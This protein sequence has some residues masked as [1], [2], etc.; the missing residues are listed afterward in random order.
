MQFH[1][2]TL[3]NRPK[4]LH[5]YHSLREAGVAPS[6]HTY[7]LLLDSYSL[8][9]PLDLESLQAVFNE[10]CQDPQVPVQGVHWASLITAYGDIARDVEKALAIFE[11]IPTHPASRGTVNI[12]NEAVVW[13][14]LLGVL[15]TRGT[16][17]QMETYSQ[18]LRES[19][20]KITAY[21]CN[22]LIGGYARC[23]AMDKAREVFESMGDG[24]MGVAAPNNH[25]VLLTSSG[26]VKPSTM[27]TEPTRVVFREPSTYETMIRVEVQ[28]GQTLGGDTED[29]INRAKVILSKM[30]DRG[31]PIAVFMRAKSFLDNALAERTAEQG[32]GTGIGAGAEDFDK[33][34]NRIVSGGYWR[35][36]SKEQGDEWTWIWNTAK[37]TIKGGTIHR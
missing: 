33:S 7:K 37:V 21:V 5:Y 1:L 15:G 25:P 35:S 9:S 2:R 36:W 22:V 18:R 4:V 28:A 20:A 11:G 14:A 8:I 31:Y 27:T 29:A 30:H 23:G 12:Q 24:M 16:L 10:L 3:P 19:G 34:L 17:S 32:A 6:A 26:H 13:E